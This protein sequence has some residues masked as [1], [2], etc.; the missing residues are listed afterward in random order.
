MWLR[1]FSD[2]LL[3]FPSAACTCR[4]GMHPSIHV[5]QE[6]CVVLARPAGLR[7][8]FVIVGAGGSKAHQKY[9][10]GL[11]ARFKIWLHKVTPNRLRELASQSLS[12]HL[13]SFA[14]QPWRWAWS[15]VIRGQCA[16]SVGRW[17]LLFRLA[18]P[19]Q[20]SWLS[21]LLPP[22]RGLV[23]GNRRS[24]DSGMAHSRS[25]ENR[26]GRLVTLSRSGN[27]IVTHLPLILFND[28]VSSLPWPTNHLFAVLSCSVTTE[29]NL[30]C[31]G[32]ERSY[33]F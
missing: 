13:L 8:H 10:Q 15:T 27:I 32:V 6:G 3:D 30:E 25:A 12:R 14:A 22:R 31:T 29:G 5:M 4:T 16:D 23:R 7:R 19:A 24:S 2:P 17:G 1:C 11:K 18:L 20:G 28:T 33:F 9:L 26:K 21:L